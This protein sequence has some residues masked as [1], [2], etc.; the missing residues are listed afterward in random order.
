MN[1]K[2]H[3][4]LLMTAAS[5]APTLQAQRSFWN[6]AEAYLGQTPP[7]GIPKAFAPGLLADPGMFVMGRIAFSR[8]GKEFYYAQNDSWQSGD[9]ASMKMVRYANHRWGKPA[10]LSQ[11]FLSPTFAPDGK[12]LYVRRVIKGGSMKNVWQSR[13]TGN[14]W[15]APTPFLQETYGVY[16]FMPTSSGNAYVGSDPSPDDAKNGI[17]YAYSLLTTSNGSPTIKSLGRPLN[18]PG[19]NGDLYIAPDEAYMIVSAKES[20]TYESEL[21]I[22]FR[23]SDSTWTVPVSLGPGINN[24]P[25]HRWGQYVTPNGKYLFYTRGT[26]EKDCAIYWVRFDGLLKSLRAK[27]L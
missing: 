27:E 10:T 26:S 18:E 8:D 22:S 13:R 25:A 19:F 16:D 15:T 11:H 7:A 4:V 3:T 21:Y 2:P 12:T 14:S 9:H 23:K 24:G 6:N 1:V 17:T 20:K 5:L